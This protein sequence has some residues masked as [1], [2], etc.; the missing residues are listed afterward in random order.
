MTTYD[1]LDWF[2]AYTELFIIKKE[3]LS[4]PFIFLVS[5]LLFQLLAAQASTR[6]VKLFSEW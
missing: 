3:E 2:D 5:V 4:V 1:L 6:F